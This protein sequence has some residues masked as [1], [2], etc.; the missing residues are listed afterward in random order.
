MMVKQAVSMDWAEEV[1]DVEVVY[2]PGV[3]NY[4]VR[5]LSCLYL[6]DEPGSMCVRSKYMYN[7]VMRNDAACAAECA[8]SVNAHPCWKGRRGHVGI[9]STPKHRLQGRQ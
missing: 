4:S 7:I 2:I 9:L 5:C 8:H 3:E 6:N 1:F